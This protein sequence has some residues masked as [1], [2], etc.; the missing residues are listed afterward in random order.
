MEFAFLG[1]LVLGVLGDLGVRAADECLGD[2]VALVAE[3]DGDGG[4][5]IGRG[6]PGADMGG[7]GE[8]ASWMKSVDGKLSRGLCM[9]CLRGFPRFCHVLLLLVLILDK[10]FL[11]MKNSLSTCSFMRYPHQRQLQTSQSKTPRRAP[12][13]FLSKCCH[14]WCAKRLLR[15]RRTFSPSTLDGETRFLPWFRRLVLQGDIL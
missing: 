8:T 9:S 11:G 13:L 1:V 4:T 5:R 2:C 6:G 15:L 14:P 12:P 7:G 3:A 10:I